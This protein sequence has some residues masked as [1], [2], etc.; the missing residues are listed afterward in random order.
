MQRFINVST[1][2]SISHKQKRLCP[3]PDRAF[4]ILFDCGLHLDLNLYTAWELELH[5]GINSLGCCAIDV[6][7]TLEL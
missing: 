6:D 5:Q 7:H 2:I 3:H 1:Y 4:L